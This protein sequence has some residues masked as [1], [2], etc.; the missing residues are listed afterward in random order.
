MSFDEGKLLPRNVTAH[1]R[2]SNP[3]TGKHRIAGNPASSRLESGVGN[4][5]PGLECD[6]RNLERRFVP[7]MEMDAV[8]VVREIRLVSVD[9]G[10]ALQAARAGEITREDFEVYQTLSDD[11]GDGAAAVVSRLEGSFGVLG[12]LAFDLSQLNDKSNGP[13]RRPPDSWTAVRMLTEGAPL[14]VSFTRGDGTGVTLNT[15]RERYLDDEGALSSIFLPGEMSQSLCSPWTH[16]FRDCGCHYWASNHPDIVQ[17]VYPAGGSGAQ[18]QK[19]TVSVPWQRADRVVRDE[20]PPSAG[21]F[22]PDGALD[23]HEINHRWEELHFVINTRETTSPFRPGVVHGAP[24]PNRAVLLRHLRYAAGVE[25]AVAHEYLAAAFSFKPDGDPSLAGDDALADSIRAAR[26]EIMRIAIGEMRHTR[27]VNDVIRAISPPGAFKPALQVADALPRPGG[28]HR[29]VVPRVA[30]RAAIDDFID[31]EA[32][33]AGVDGLYMDILATLENPPSDMPE[34][35][36]KEWA[37]A[38]SSIIAE[39]EDHFQTF[40]D[41]REWLG[42]YQEAK[43]LRDPAATQPDAAQ[44]DH[45]ALQAAYLGVLDDLHTG[46]TKGRFQGATEINEARRDMVGAGLS[47]LASAVAAGGFIVVFN[48]VADPRFAPISPP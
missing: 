43:Y 4:C 46:Y 31:I 26:A 7:F 1:R 17:P 37:E 15:K 41:I 28:G 47:S 38:V 13:N 12:E 5:Y 18:D 33:S 23:H 35:V 3:A 16:D 39:G 25:L 40:L 42:A 32:P 6:V 45:V 22:R 29:P 8:A 2:L 36:A 10:A 9:L 14:K 11:L 19:W 27:A 24:L 34:G 48:V 21:P 44:P 20:P 30:S